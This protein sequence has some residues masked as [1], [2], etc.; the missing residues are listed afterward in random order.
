MDY[1]FTNYFLGLSQY[2]ATYFQCD[3]TM[4][5]QNDKDKPRSRV[6]K[7]SNSLSLLTIIIAVLLVLSFGLY[8]YVPKGFF[9]SIINSNKENEVRDALNS[10]QVSPP[11]TVTADSQ[12]DK[13]SIQS[14]QRSL[15]NSEKQHTLNT[16]DATELNTGEQ[17]KITSSTS[18]N[19]P[20]QD[21]KIQ[22]PVSNPQP[23]IDEINA[24]YAHLDQQGYMQSF[25]LKEPS[26]VYFS[27]LLQK[28]LDNPPVVIRETDDLFTLLHNTAHFFRILGKNNINVLKTILEREG[29]S[30]EK[31][32]SAFYKL[33]YQ[34]EYLKKEYSLTIP[35][36][37]LSNYA[38]FF[39]TTMGGRLYLFRRDSTSRML[40]SY[41]AI[42][43]IDRANKNGNG[44][45][46]IDLRPAI[47]SLIDEIE[48]GGSQL[49]LKDEYL[50][51]LYDLQ[52]KYN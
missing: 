38:G 42:I 19:L 32:L 13:K 6:K 23:L 37:A 48:I 1:L 51:T 36:H 43:T 47:R 20:G 3:K 31:M 46:G 10:G 15:P 33:T 26:K 28:L 12:Q 41:Y 7:R 44:G 30:F 5:E 9:P 29:D 27:K 11:M 4:S 22:Y 35:D 34:P 39:L 14:L 2:S 45:H 21:S 17:E 52:E 18:S 25:G 24:F 50:E 40:V 16:V 49:K 8:L